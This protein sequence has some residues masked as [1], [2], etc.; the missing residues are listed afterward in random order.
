MNL[1]I[2]LKLMH[3]NNLTRKSFLRYSTHIGMNTTHGRVS[4]EVL[5]VHCSGKLFFVDWMTETF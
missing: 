2:T 4:E 5:Y 3:L 1:V